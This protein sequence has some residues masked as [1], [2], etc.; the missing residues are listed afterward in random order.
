[1]NL[2]DQ[3]MKLS[4]DVQPVGAEDPF[5]RGYKFGHRDARDRAARL[6]IE[7]DVAMEVACKHASRQAAQIREQRELIEQMAEVI[8]SARCCVKD[9]SAIAQRIDAALSAVREYSNG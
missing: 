5:C 4:D 2:H 8:R 7:A 6:A 1:M 9:G 3:I